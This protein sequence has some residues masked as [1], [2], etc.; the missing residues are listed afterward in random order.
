VEKWNYITQWS[1]P[2]GEMLDLVSPGFFGWKTGDPSGPYWGVCG[3]SAEWEK[4]RQGFQNFRLDSSYIGLLPFALALIGLTCCFGKRPN[5]AWVCFWSV[6]A[7]ASLVLAFGKF[8]FAYKLFYQLPLVN[9]I[10][11]PIKFLHVFQVIIGILCGIGWDAFR[12][13]SGNRKIMKRLSVVFLSVSALFLLGGVIVWLG[14]GAVE[15]SLTAQGWG[16][17]AAVIA[18]RM[19]SALLHSGAVSLPMGGALFLLW[20]KPELGRK[21]ALWAC[22]GV[23]FFG[24]VLVDVY[25]LTGKYFHSTSYGNLRKGNVVI[26]HL[27][28]VQGNQRIFFFDTG[29][30][31][32]QWLAQDVP[33]HQL[34]VFN[35]WQMPRMPSDYKAYL[36]SVGKNWFRLLQLGSVEYA[37][38]PAELLN[39]LPA[40]AF[41][42]VMFYRFIRVGDG[43]G[44]QQIMRPEHK[45]DQAMLRFKQGLSRFALFSSW[46]LVASGTE[47]SVLASPSF[48]PLM[49]LVVTQDEASTALPSLP[50]GGSVYQACLGVVNGV[51]AELDVD[52]S[53]GV[54]LFT[55]HYQPGWR[56]FVNGQ[57]QP[58]LRC[59]SINMGVYLPKGMHR[60]RFVCPKS[61]GGFLIQAIGFIGAFFAGTVL[62]I[63]HFK[64]GVEPNR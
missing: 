30:V 19:S 17:S 8:S 63:A 37:L 41:E 57:K 42:P 52:S 55:Q 28:S 62:L 18:S 21:P 14:K 1:F 25:L 20:I 44:T 60:V 23:L 61:Y 16:D 53:G 10:R 29:N 43:I 50:I 58:L 35:I 22:V 6:A 11:A 4:N 48:D 9:N 64:T 33:Y 32:N 40:D 5:R 54:L 34:N 2:P 51:S 59:N 12:E 38:S 3:Q 45:N 26:N 46:E 47:N 31:Y 39:K 36:G 13:L 24:V 56:V 7:V 15:A 49:T 27:K